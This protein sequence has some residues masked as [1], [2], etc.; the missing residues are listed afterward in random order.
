M[1]LL[2][3]GAAGWR[4]LLQDRKKNAEWFQERLTQVAEREG[5][6]VLRCPANRI[7]FVVDLSPLARSLES[8]GLGDS[9]HLTFLGSALFTRRVSGPRVVLCTLPSA[10]AAAPPDLAESSEGTVE[11]P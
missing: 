5:L 7:S 4:G 11:E 8:K 10:P 2:S 6:R 9:D 1:T 3:L